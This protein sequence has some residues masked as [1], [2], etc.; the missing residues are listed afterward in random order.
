MMFCS[1]CGAQIPASASFC[2]S[3][4]APRDAALSADGLDQQPRTFAGSVTLCFRRY[5]QFK[6][7]APRSEYWYFV[8]FTSL[9]HVAADLADLLCFGPHHEIFAPIVSLVLLIPGLAVW[10]RRMHDLDR[11][12]WWWLLAFVPV[13]GWVILLVWTCTRG[14][15]GPNRYGPDPLGATGLQARPATA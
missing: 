15:N 4:G 8:L 10:T 14:T 11:S 2:P 3:C 6:G 5:F 12:G 7:R 13:I 9:A 1:G